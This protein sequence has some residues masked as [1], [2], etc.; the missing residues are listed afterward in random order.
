VLILIAPSAVASHTVAMAI[1]ETIAAAIKETVEATLELMGDGDAFTVPTAS[2][3][4]VET[5]PHSASK[6][7]FEDDGYN[8]RLPR[9]CSSMRSLTGSTR[10]AAG[11]R[12]SLVR[13]AKW[14]F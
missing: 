9:H 6:V 8:Y 5:V 2:G 1:V 11:S 14:I 12:T 4:H 13:R 10:A 7:R 3:P